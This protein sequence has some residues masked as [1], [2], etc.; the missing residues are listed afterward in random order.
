MTPNPARRLAMPCFAIACLW[1]LIG[2]GSTS[3]GSP[4]T[5]TGA[6]AGPTQEVNP[7]GDIPDD[8]VFVPYVWP[9]GGFSVSVPE[10]WS[11]T[12]AGGAVVF[13]DK[14]NSVRIETA[15]LAQAPTVE[16]AITGEL[17][18]IESSVTNYAAG[19]ITTV[20]RSAGDA[21][22]I[23]YTGDSEPDAVT[24]R[25]VTDSFE[26]YEFWHN[27]IEVILT[28]SGPQGADNVDPW[29]IVADSL[30]WLS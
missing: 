15:A 13:T 6:S 19:D 2:C 9:A 29:R 24:G 21:V 23:T 14:L 26:R 22:L 18:T 12:E 17:P 1:V 27:G 3:G 30:Q 25:T 10:G 8:Q 16:S 11:R 28:L 5:D 7:A 4:S 20:T